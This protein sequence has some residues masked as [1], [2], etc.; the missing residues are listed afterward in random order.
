[1]R[2]LPLREGTD[3]LHI[4]KSNAVCQGVMLGNPTFPERSDLHHQLGLFAVGQRSGRTEDFDAL[5]RRQ[6]PIER[7]GASVPGEQSLGRG[8]HQAALDEFRH[9]HLNCKNG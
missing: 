5:P 9:G 8:G 4:T 1:M 7:A 3:D 6:Q 2:M